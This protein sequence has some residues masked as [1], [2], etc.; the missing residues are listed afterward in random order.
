MTCWWQDLTTG[1]VY[2]RPDKSTCRREALDRLAERPTHLVYL[3]VSRIL[4][5]HA[6]WW[7]DAGCPSVPTMRNVLEPVWDAAEH[8]DVWSA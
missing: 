7:R 5:G 6:Q 2:E 3:S 1:E 4:P 8:E